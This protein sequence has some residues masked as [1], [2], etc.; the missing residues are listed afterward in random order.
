MPSELGSGYPVSTS[1][2]QI[3][4]II[5]GC[6]GGFFFVLT[7][8]TVYCFVLVARRGKI[9]SKKDNE[10]VNGDGIVKSRSVDEKLGSQLSLHGNGK[11][12]GQMG[13]EQPLQVGDVATLLNKIPT[14]KAVVMQHVDGQPI[15]SIK[16]GPFPDVTQVTDYPTRDISIH[17]CPPRDPPPYAAQ[18]EINQATYQ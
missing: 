18:Q 6:I 5:Y 3:D 9:K 4:L 8:I 10:N 11:E 1:K 15:G 14:E 12:N 13:E 7:I 16:V 17:D 2:L